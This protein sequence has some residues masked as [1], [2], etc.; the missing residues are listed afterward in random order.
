MTQFTRV[1]DGTTEL[2]AVLFND[3]QEAI[4]DLGSPGVTVESLG[5]VALDDDPVVA[6]NNTALINAHMETLTNTHTDPQNVGKSMLFPAEPIYI[7]GA[8]VF[9]Q[10]L[11]ALSWHGM[12]GGSTF[13]GQ[14]G[15]GLKQITSGQH[16]L[17][18][19]QD[20]ISHNAPKIIGMNFEGV[21]GTAA[22]KIR[23]WNR[24]TLQN[25]YIFAD[26]APCIDGAVEDFGGEFGDCAWWHLNDVHFTG[27]FSSAILSDNFTF[28]M[29][30][31][32]MTAVDADGSEPPGGHYGFNGLFTHCGAFGVKTDG[33]RHIIRGTFNQF[34]VQSEVLEG[35]NQAWLIGNAS[36]DP[37]DAA[38]EDFDFLTRDN[39]F[40][41]KIAG[42]GTGITSPVHYGEWARS[43]FVQLSTSNVS[44]TYTE[45]TDWR[46]VPWRN[47]T[48]TVGASNENDGWQINQP[49]AGYAF[50]MFNS[51]F[52]AYGG[53]DMILRGSES[54]AVKILDL[55]SPDAS[56][57]RN[58][59]AYFT[60]DGTVH[61]LSHLKHGAGRGDGGT[62][63]VGFYGT[64]P[65]AKQT[66]V[67]VTAEAVHAALVALGLIGS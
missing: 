18:M 62:P 49:V 32:E 25:C 40:H 3:L 66:G 33:V 44:G 39:T 54:A 41:L 50:D 58:S 2:R 11:Y 63:T 22:I 48:I 20:S 60:G 31:G 16:V 52:G 13:N 10:N 43:N 9:P 24:G 46:G 59:F 28:Q 57:A 7:S 55:E 51:H 26:S 12:G 42:R 19:T 65:I 64:A 5:V 29:T 38:S 67:A 45:D 23:N 36:W 53:Q 1:V 47:S 34:H 30:G 27:P 4:E 21:A 14:N 61:V 56:F 6:A 8:I 37:D 17:N 35:E 15:S